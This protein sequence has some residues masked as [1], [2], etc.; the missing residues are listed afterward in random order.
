MGGDSGRSERPRVAVVTPV[1]APYR[2]PAFN[3]LAARGDV[4]LLVLYQS[5]TSPI[6]GWEPEQ[7]AAR[8][9]FEVLP[10]VAAFGSG[11][12][13][14]WLSRGVVRH[15]ARFRP[16]VVVLGGANQPFTWEIFAARRVLGYQTWIWVESTAK[17]ARSGGW[18]REIVKRALVR[19][20]DGILVP[21]RA[22]RDYALSM[23]VDPDRVRF[24][25]NAVDV[26][27][28][29]ASA[30]E[31]AQERE[32]IRERLGLEGTVF[33]F[34]GRMVR[35]KGIFDLLEAFERSAETLRTSGEKCT[36][37]V[38]GDG[39]DMEAFSER[40]RSRDIGGV[41]T[42]GFVQQTELPTL[43]A[44]SDVLVFPTWSDAWGM[45]LN[46]AQAC[47]LPAIVSDVAG[48]SADLLDG[49]GAGLLVP[50]HS[51]RGLAEA[52]TTLA[53]DESLRSSM[54]QAA[55]KISQRFTPEVCAAG[56][57]EMAQLAGCRAAARAADTRGSV[58]HSG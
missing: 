26:Q 36:L 39:P 50:A 10:Y 53:T 33:T 14:V 19:W 4:E 28:F 47:G 45:I 57:A 3:A 51:P 25:P 41:V 21:G 7:E 35:E 54:S 1:M 56:F 27:G 20:A 49:T 34:V 16:D 55:R 38:A 46:E 40:V 18:V 22:S 37:L 44:A 48:A 12:R 9:R 42:V 23:G 29:S 17:D 2:T 31:A 32:A 43:L 11:F 24:V 30:A 52:M 5:E 15:L 6:H 13:R 58:A 8:F